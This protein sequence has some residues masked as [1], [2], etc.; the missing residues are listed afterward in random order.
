MNLHDQSVQKD[1]STGALRIR[2]LEQVVAARDGDYRK[3]GGNEDRKASP[4][5]ASN[6]SHIKDSIQSDE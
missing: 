3:N 1:F 2:R 6:P 4:R 5:K